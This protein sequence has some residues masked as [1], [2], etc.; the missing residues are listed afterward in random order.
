MHIPR[1]IVTKTYRPITGSALSVIYRT[2]SQTVAVLEG[3]SAEVWDRLVRA[4]GNPAHALDY[5]RKHGQFGSD[6]EKESQEVLDSFLQSLELQGIAGDRGDVHTCS[7]GGHLAD[8]D[9]GREVERFINLWMAQHRIL[10]SLVIELTYRCNEQCVHCYCPASRERNELSVESLY[11]LVSEYELLGGLSL[12][13][14]GGEFFLSPHAK[15]LLRYLCGR[16]LLISISSNLTL[17][18][19]ETVDLLKDIVPRSVSCSVYSADPDVHD[20]ITTVP[21]SF[22]RTRNGIIML[23]KAG[24]PVVIKTPLMNHTVA[25]WSEVEALAKDLGSS[26]QFD[27]NITARNDGDCHPLDLRVRDEAVIRS[28]YATRYKRLYSHDEPMENAVGDSGDRPI[29]GAGANG[30]L[31]APDGTI[32]PCI[33]LPLDLGKY[34]SDSLESVWKTSPFFEMW[35]N[36]HMYD[37]PQC[38]ACN[39]RSSCTPCPGA[40]YVETGSYKTPN[41]YTCYLA[42]CA[43]ESMSIADSINQSSNMKGGVL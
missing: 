30:L 10:Y 22:A 13:L 9:Q 21:G 39:Y 40:W 15:K 24:I 37:I 41:N 12:Q 5:I 8:S 42:R 17:V 38:R 14:T 19:E 20:S 33:G 36:L 27:L 4:A 1:D 31:V 3:D 23:R 18:D 7:Q 32:R 29:C 6:P 35:G 11:G 26:C 28:L 34:P 43:S 25:G 2:I 16:G